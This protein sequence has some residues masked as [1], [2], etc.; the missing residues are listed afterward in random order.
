ME[1]TNNVTINKPLSLILDE[2][3]K[4][5][6]D[7]INNIGLHPTLLEMILKE[8]YI[9]ARQNAISQYE[10]EKVEYEKALQESANIKE[11]AE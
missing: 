9:E 11:P 4:V 5:I 7:T 10:R 6:I 2:S 8:I 3:K 1:N